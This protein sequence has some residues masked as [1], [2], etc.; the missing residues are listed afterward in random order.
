MAETLTVA[1]LQDETLDALCWRA[2]GQTETVVEEALRLNPG[3]A[4]AGP[5]LAEGQ[6]ITLPILTT[7]RLATRDIIQLWD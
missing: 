2:L 5:L 4:D 6:V 3:L 1:A 7:Q